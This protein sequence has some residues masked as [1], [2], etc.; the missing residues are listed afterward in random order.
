MNNRTIITTLAAPLLLLCACSKTNDNPT[1]PLP[2]EMAFELHTD[3]AKAVLNYTNASTQIGVYTTYTAGDKQDVTITTEG[4]PNGVLNQSGIK[5]HTPPGADT[6][7]LNTINAKPGNYT[8][9]IKATTANGMAQNIQ[10][11][12]EVINK[13]A[14]GCEKEYAYR[15][16]NAGGTGPNYNFHTCDVTVKA[17]NTVRFG[18]CQPNGFTGDIDCNTGTITIPK[19]QAESGEYVMGTAQYV[20]YYNTPALRLKLTI[21]DANGNETG[22]V[23]LD[24]FR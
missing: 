6:I 16:N 12:L 24:L 5:K 13:Q 20:G 1:T 22:K 9:T 18:D 19:Q 2:Q 3:A 8:I 21:M 17:K 10:L 15:Y 23:D 4:L 14:L 7:V 11:P